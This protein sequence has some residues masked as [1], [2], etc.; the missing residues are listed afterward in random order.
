MWGPNHGGSSNANQCRTYRAVCTRQSWAT[1]AREGQAKS[2]N[3]KFTMETWDLE[4]LAFPL[5]DRSP[6][7]KEAQRRWAA[8]KPAQ[9][10]LPG[11]TCKHTNARCQKKQVTNH[12]CN[13]TSAT[14]AMPAFRRS[15]EILHRIIRP[16]TRL[17]KATCLD[18]KCPTP[19]IKPRLP[20]SYATPPASWPAVRR[21]A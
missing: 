1:N 13:R 18:S 11:R 7:P 4:G 21:K 6:T 19:A 2:A 5:A 17:G 9:V 8:V 3:W 20:L 14:L 12:A 10:K 16:G 15:L